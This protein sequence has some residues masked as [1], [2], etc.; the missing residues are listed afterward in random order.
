MKKKSY[1]YLRH[2]QG[3]LLLPCLPANGR[4]YLCNDGRPRASIVKH[5][6]NSRFNHRHRII[7][8]GQLGPGGPTGICDTALKRIHKEKPD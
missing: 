6:R 2:R 4:R 1:E 5:R 3:A 8:S 7:P